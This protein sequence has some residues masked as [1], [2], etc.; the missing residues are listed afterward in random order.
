MT[1]HKQRLTKWIE[2]NLF[3][4]MS[5]YTFIFA[6]F[7]PDRS[8]AL[9]GVKVILNQ[10]GIL[11]HDYLEIG[12]VSATFINVA[13]HFL[14]AHLLYRLSGAKELKGAYVASVFFSC[15]HAFFGSHFL[16]IIPPMIGVCLYSWW[17]RE[18][19]AQNFA[20]AM[21]ANSLGPMSSVIWLMG[22][23]SIGSLVAGA[24]VGVIIGMISVPLANKTAKFH[25]GMTL[26]NY[27][28]V[29]GLIGI[30][31]T[32][33]MAQ[34]HMEV[35]PVNIISTHAH[36]HITDYLMILS[37]IFILFALSQWQQVKENYPKLILSRGIAGAD[38]IQTY[39]LHTASLNMAL[40]VLVGLSFIYAIQFPMNGT[41]IG[42]MLSLMAFGAAGAHPLNVVPTMLGVI[43]AGWCYGVN[44][45]SNG[46][47]LPMLFA[48]GLSPLT[49]HYGL[50]GGLFAGF[51]H[52]TLLSK[53]LTLHLGS[54]LYNNGFSTGFIAIFLVP[55]FDAI[56]EKRT[57]RQ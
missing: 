56:R 30:V 38:F 22:G 19:I 20:F 31:V 23:H 50:L 6:M 28:Y 47:V 35:T 2:R 40:N 24:I 45:S 18:S 29:A 25:G 37:V 36:A 15:G 13:V 32:A 11:T 3:L 42:A 7:M 17:A 4:M 5:V 1:I 39:G 27:G 43:L 44:L 10:S 9:N 33:V 46:V 57:L 26:L 55:I 52:M 41:S 34:L 49:S 54:T 51:M 48:F 14:I 16:N 8:D 21:Y 12:G 53:T